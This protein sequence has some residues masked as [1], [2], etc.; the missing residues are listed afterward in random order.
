MLINWLFPGGRS[1]IRNL[2]Q[3]FP[4]LETRRTWALRGLGNG[5]HDLAANVA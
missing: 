4:G 5:D 3:C 1:A 2:Q